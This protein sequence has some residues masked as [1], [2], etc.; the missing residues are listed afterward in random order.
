[1]R[2][3]DVLI[4]GGGPAAITFANEYK[5]IKPEADVALFRP[6]A[7]SMVYCAIPYAIEGLFDS[8]KVFK[9]D[10]LVTD[11]GVE[12]L[13]RSVLAVNFQ[14]QEV[15]DDVGDT[16]GYRTLFVATGAS[17]IRPPIPGADAPYV[18]TVKTEKDMRDIITR[19][20]NGAK[21][22]VVVGAGAVGIEQAQAYRK[23]G[24]ETWLI[25]IAPYVLPNM[26][27]EE[28]AT[29]LKEELD[30]FGVHTILGSRVE[31]L[32]NTASG[33]S[34]VRL[35]SGED[36]EIN[37]ETDFV[38]FAVGMKPDI[39][40]FAK[41]GL[42]TTHD[43]IVVDPRMRTSIPS[44]YAAG[45]CCAFNSAIDNRPVGGKLATAAVPMAKVAARVA[46]GKN[47]EYPG[48][49]NGAATCVGEWRIGS[50]GFTA[51]IA[52]KRGMSTI[53]GYGE[54]TTI[55]PMMPGAKT[56]KV[57]IIADQ[58]HLRIVGGQILSK[59][60][61]TDKTDIVTLAIQRRMTLKGLS[62]LAYSAQPWQSFFPARNAIVAACENA[63]DH[64][65]ARG[66]HMEQTEMLE[67]V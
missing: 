47:D 11:A 51:V 3:R 7:H 61:A 39:E 34:A 22:A 67:C 12:L 54:T 9:R 48:F 49:Y 5:R 35:S 6:E 53:A 64:L 44:V 23:C 42:A 26:I 2:S 4:V 16:H 41:A 13:R 21:R 28:M 36:I 33:V 63:L 38:C 18:F 14:K 25:D 27:D 40:I 65:A 1:M 56:L 31:S 37:P 62:R 58:Q 50:T 52:E 17:P 57:K 32:R 29:H 55:F 46:A 8:S 15:S 20:K 43:G 30:N 45:D 60:P 66:V 19:I 10:E 24:I 59:F